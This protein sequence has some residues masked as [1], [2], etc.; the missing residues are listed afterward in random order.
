[1]PTETEIKLRVAATIPEIHNRI[2]SL[3]YRL[4]RPRT[5][6]VDQ[7]YDSQGGELREAGKVLRIR[8][9]DSITVLTFKG[10]AFAGLSQPRHKSREEIETEV[11]NGAA[12]ADI[13]GGLGYAPGFRYEKYRTKYSRPG[14][15]GEITL[16]E[17]PMGVF[18]EL[19]GLPEWIDTTASGLGFTTAEYLTQSY[20][21]L[22]AAFRASHPAVPENMTF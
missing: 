19:E 21:T 15:S 14:E 3:G 12:L 13:L 10:P 9:A 16:D 7:L 8:S 20:P 17:T 18:L 5:L 2:E 4:T 11:R 6:E 1:M 22:Y